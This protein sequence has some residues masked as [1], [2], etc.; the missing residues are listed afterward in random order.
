MSVSITTA[1]SHVIAR[2][3]S[4]GVLSAFVSISRHLIRT[5]SVV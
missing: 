4:H 1:L 5:T 2:G 3:Y